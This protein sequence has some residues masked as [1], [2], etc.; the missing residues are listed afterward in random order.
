MASPTGNPN[1]PGGQFLDVHKLFKQQPTPPNQNQISSPTPTGPYSYPP[2]PTNTQFHH[3]YHPYQLNNNPP[4]TNPINPGAR[5][6]ALLTT[7]PPTQLPIPLQPTVS[8]IPATSE[9]SMPINPRV[10]IPN[11]PVSSPLPTS[12]PS[13]KLPTGRVL[14]GDYVVYDVDKRLQGEVQPQLEVTPIT[15]YG[16]D[17]SLVVG[18]QIAVNRSYICYGLKLGNVRILNINTALRALL[19]GHV[20]RVTDMAFFREEVHLLASVS[21]DGRLFV[22]KINEGPDAEKK[23]QITGETVVAIQIVVEGAPVHPRVCW[24]SHKQVKIWED[25]K[26]L[27]L[28]VLRPHD[29]QPVYA[30]N[31]LTATDRPNHINLVTAGPLN[32]E[33]KIWTSASEEGW[34]LA[35]DAES[36]R[37]TQIL[38]L[39]SSTEPRVEEAFFNQVLALPHAG[40]I[41][42]ANAKKNAIYAVHIEYGPNPAATHMDYIAEFTVAMPILSLTGTSDCLP[43]GEHVVQVYCVQTQAIQQYALEL[44]QCLPP[45]PENTGLEKTDS[46]VYSE[47]NPPNSDGFGSADS[48]TVSD[49]PETPTP[50]SR[51]ESTPTRKYPASSGDSEVPSSPNISGKVS[52]FT[53]ASDNIEVG[54][55]SS[56]HGVDKTAFDYSVGRKVDPVPSSIPVIPS[57]DESLRRNEQEV[58]QNNVSVVTNPPIVFKHPTHLITPS[59]ILSRTVSS[60]ENC[61]VIQGM[62]EEAKVVVSNDDEAV[63]V[64]VKVVGETGFVNKVEIDSQREHQKKKTFSSQASSLSSGMVGDC[65]ALSTESLTLVTRQADNGGFT[66]AL[67]RS[68]NAGEEEILDSEDVPEKVSELTTTTTS[69]QQTIPSLKGKKQKGKN[70]Q[71]SGPSSPSRSP[72]NSM[73]SSNESGSNSGVPSMEAAFSQVLLMQETLNQQ[74]T[75]QKE[76]PKQM[77]TIVA[78]AVTK[79]GKRLEAALSRGTEKAVRSHFD[80]MWARLQEENAKREKLQQ[81]CTQQIISFISNVMNKDLPATFE[82]TLKKELTSFAQSVARLVTPACREINFYIYCRFISG[83]DLLSIK[84]DCFRKSSLVLVGSHMYFCREEW[85]KKQWHNWRSLLVPNLIPQLRGK[86][87]HSF[88]LLASK[89][90]S[91]YSNSAVMPFQCTV[92][93]AIGISIKTGLYTIVADALRSTLEAS[94]IPAF[95]MSC[96]AMFEQVDM[97][98]QKGLVE[99][100]AAAQQKFDTVHSPLTLAL[101]IR[102]YFYG[103]WL[104]FDKETGDA[105]EGHE[106]INSASLITQTLTGELAEGQRKLLALS[107]AGANSNT[108]N[109]L[110]TQLSNGPMGRNHDTAMPIEAPLDPTIELS[111]LISERKFGE[112]FTGALQRSDV[113]IVSWLCSQGILGMVPLPLSQ[114]VLLALLQQLACDISN[115]TSQKLT[116]MREAVVAINPADPMIAVHVRPIFEQVYQRL[117]HTC[118]TPTTTAAEKSSIRLVMHVINS[119]LMSCK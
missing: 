109:P 46:G 86:S 91:Q 67:N 30:A 55:S 38:D 32:R 10:L 71:K 47:L 44:S 48:V 78:A 11:H 119:M 53:N 80:A 45:T 8:S 23:Q 13:K 65:C 15:K 113:S 74:T 22:W 14:S 105:D 12:Q 2:Q 42:L 97:V 98:F 96:K 103:D 70:V 61:E 106:A 101:R 102:C 16:S 56:A 36:W 21:E 37:C 63:E 7:E 69:L 104:Y 75:M 84:F 40:L 33:V 88:R 9:Y 117:G 58:I 28:V 31:F 62:K 18:R 73:D 5:L 29:G 66:E 81:E 20:Q 76:M 87:K 25:R 114:G 19:R 92:I 24:H 59:E 3:H 100:T 50:V 77:T 49:A 41:L 115:D 95:E 34:L 93:S 68:P 110:V 57:L 94:V 39:K 64:E 116:W 89:L 112:A 1:Q 107:V 99:H 43:E 90:F 60:F 6:M 51:S 79:E 72:F 83:G 35:S 108:V 54:L 82:R 27:P 111:R 4:T 26:A 118:S 17:P 52:G 85:E